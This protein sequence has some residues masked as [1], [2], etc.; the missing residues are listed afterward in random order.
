MTEDLSQ[1]QQTDPSDGE[2]SDDAF[3]DGRLR[4]YQPVQG[5][6][7]AVDALFLAAAIPARSG[8]AVLEAGTGCGI[9]SLALAYRVPGLR[10]TALE[11]QPQLA[12]L[13]ERNAARNGVTSLRVLTADV[14]WPFSRLAA[15][16]VAREA[17][18]HVFANP[19]FHER[20]ASRSSASLSRDRAHRGETGFLARWLRFLTT[21]CAPHG[22]LSL[23]HRPEALPALLTHLAGRFGDIAIFP[24]FSRKGQPAKRILIQGRKGSRAPVRLCAGLVLHDAE[25]RFTPEA[26]AVLRHGAPLSLAG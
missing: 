17:A 18:H 14:T 25:G 12:A 5:P 20:A 13:A 9:V 23:I 16:G 2:L 19:P 6:R 11:I 4:L 10:M 15:L 8:E 24:L 1:T 7:V 3:L 22:S 21:A 26:E